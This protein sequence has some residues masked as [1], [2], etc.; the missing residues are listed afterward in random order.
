MGRTWGETNADRAKPGRPG[1]MMVAKL[2]QTAGMR[3][4]LFFMPV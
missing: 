1:I 3:I 2:S 4:I